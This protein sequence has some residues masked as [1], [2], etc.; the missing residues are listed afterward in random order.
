MSLKRWRAKRS[1]SRSPAV[2]ADRQGTH[3]YRPRLEILE[4]RLAPTISLSISNPAP[5]PKGDF[6]TS[7]GLFVV[8]RSGDLAPPVQVHYATQDGTAHAATDYVA[9]SG[10]L[11][12]A[13]NQTTA[14]IA[15]PVIGNNLFEPNLTFTVALSNPLALAT[16]SPP[17]NLATGA[18]PVAAA[19]GDFTGDGQ[20]DLAVANFASNT[21]SVFLNQTTPGAAIPLFSPPQTF[22]TGSGPRALE[23]ADVNGDGRPDLIVVNAGADTV[24]VLLNQT[25]P[26][27][28]VASFSPQQIFTAGAGPVAL[29]VA[30]LN[31]DGL[32]DLIVADADATAVSVLLN[33]TAAGATTLSF[34]AAQAF[35]T[36]A[37]PRSVAV[38]DLNGDGRPDLVIANADA[39]SVSVLL[40]QTPPGAT[41]ASFGP[42]QTFATGSAPG[43]VAVG[44]VNGDGRPDLITANTG[45]GT[46]SVL[47]NQTPPGATVASFAPQQTFATGGAP[48]AVVIADVNGDRQP[49]LVVANEGSGTVSMLLNQTAPGATALSFFPQ[50]TFAAGSFPAS[51][52]VGDFNG[53]GQPDLLIADLFG[54]TLT[55]LM[56]QATAVAGIATF[57]PVQ[58]LAAG[59]YPRAVAAT[60]GRT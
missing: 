60:V 45:A 15:V 32:S 9:T 53:D 2:N 37:A 1:P 3:R 54:T 31:G 41:V 51:V 14:T 57:T 59:D 5:F 21:V 49:D 8:T 18:E 39:D 34:S 17:Q 44:D 22:A 12:F 4:K 10:T 20:L 47:L 38:G 40:D 33:Q 24:S 52:V 27:A 29:A 23:V 26:G 50:Q 13:A 19:V 46:V 48:D 42:Q 58:T 7:M 28:T 16:F 11:S 30:D 25:P 35:P 43:A 56:N 55:V 6:G 36:Q